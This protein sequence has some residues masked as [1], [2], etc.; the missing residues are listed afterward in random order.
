MNHLDSR[1]GV[2]EYANN[3]FKGEGVLVTINTE[4]QGGMGGK[5]VNFV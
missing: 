2:T 4:E 5:I 1:V 3:T